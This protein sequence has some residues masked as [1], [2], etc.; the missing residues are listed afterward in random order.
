MP[1]YTCYFAIVE[2][3]HNVLKKEKETETWSKARWAPSFRK[4]TLLYTSSLGKYLEHK[5]T[6][7]LSIYA[8]KHVTIRI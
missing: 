3:Q 6:S 7:K 1:N 8:V 4:R 2:I 5:I